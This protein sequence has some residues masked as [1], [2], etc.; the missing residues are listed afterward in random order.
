[1]QSLEKCIRFTHTLK[2]AYTIAQKEAKLNH[3]HFDPSTPEGD[4]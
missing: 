4:S 1:M 2:G 3:L